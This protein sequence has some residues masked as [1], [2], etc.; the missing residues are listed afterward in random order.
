MI[1]KEREK[2]PT[3]TTLEPMGY[4][5]P[6][7]A[8]SYKKKLESGELRSEFD[9]AAQEF[10]VSGKGLVVVD[11]T[12]DGCIDGRKTRAVYTF[13][14][15]EFDSNESF[16]TE[17]GEL[18]VKP[19]NNEGHER[20]KV[21]GGGYL[22]GQA[23]RLGVG[24]RG[25]SMDEDVAKLGTDLAAKEIYCGAHTGPHMHADGTDCGANDKFVP[26]LENASAFKDELKGTTAGLFGLIGVEFKE[27]V[28]DQV[29]DNWKA[30][31]DSETYFAGSTGKSRLE[32]VLATQSAA[33]EA[34]ESEKLPAV[35]K[36]LEGDHNEAYIIV[37]FVK[38]KTFSQAA[39]LEVLRREFPGVPDEQLPQA[40]V[41]DGWRV[42]ELAEAATDEESHEAGLYAGVI[43]QLATAATL[44]DGSQKVFTYTE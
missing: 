26:I 22:T 34:E 18:F 3:V 44:T 39:L 4:G 9:T 11:E 16:V 24:I 5:N 17:V 1:E 20:G 15:D 33:A 43:Y 37:N 42:A 35:T 10:I 12:D 6:D 25:E 36:E 8:I 2:K 32:T 13:S 21:A 31:A 28:F 19:A 30:V 29:I 14:Q 7:S 27:E 41:V 23:I 38:G 40:F